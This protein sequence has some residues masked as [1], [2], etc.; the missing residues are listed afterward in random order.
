[1]LS[2]QFTLKG[3][4]TAAHNT[5]G[6]VNGYAQTG[7]SSFALVSGWQPGQWVEVV[8]VSLG[9]SG[10]YRVEQVDFSLEP[11]TYIA[12]I[13]VSFSRKNPNDVAALIA[14]LGGK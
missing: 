3:A 5:L 13:T 11:G 8:S 2:G 9:L 6:F 7:A 10:L 1:M 14:R 12:I 4:G